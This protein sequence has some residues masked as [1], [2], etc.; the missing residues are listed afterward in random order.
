MALATAMLVDYIRYAHWAAA[1]TLQASA[2]LSAE[3]LHRDLHTTYASVWA[4]LVHIYQADSVWWSRFQGKHVASLTEFDAGTDLAEL[5]GRWLPLL[6]ALEGFAQARTE[7]DWQATLHYRNG[8]G[9]EFAQPLWE[10]FLHMVNHSTLHRGQVLAMFRQLD[11]VPRSV[12]LIHYY[13]QR[14]PGNGAT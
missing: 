5:S 11:C 7:Q 9:E 4:T 3:Q 1:T 2:T 13:R 6:E 10:A 8:R 12:D 14:Q